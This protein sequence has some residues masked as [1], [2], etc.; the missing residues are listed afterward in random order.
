MTK[1]KKLQIL[2]LMTCVIFTQVLPRGLIIKNIDFAQKKI[3]FWIPQV[4]ARY[5][6]KGIRMVLEELQMGC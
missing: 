3:S 2:I 1:N 5:I 6:S 4:A